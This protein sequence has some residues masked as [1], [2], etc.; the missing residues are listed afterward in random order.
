MRFFSLP[1]FAALALALT[2]S[3]DAVAYDIKERCDH[4]WE[5][6]GGEI[7]EDLANRRHR[8][9]LRCGHI[10]QVQLDAHRV[11]AGDEMF[12]SF[13][14]GS[15][16]SYAPFDENAPCGAPGSWKLLTLC[17]YGCFGADERI[18]FGEEWLTIPEALAQGIEWVS[19]LSKKSS[20]FKPVVKTDTNILTYTGGYEKHDLITFHLSSGMRLSVTK[21][22]PMVA[23]TGEI[24]RADR[25]QLG[26]RLLTVSGPAL[27]SA[28]QRAQ[29]AEK[30][31][32][33]SP[34][35]EGALDNVLIAEGFITGS[36]RFQN[37]WADHA[38]RT[39]IKD[40]LSEG[41]LSSFL[42]EPEVEEKT[43][44]ARL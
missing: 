22:H 35:S 15:K 37:E 13:S 10:S 38:S 20:V 7:Y 3:S 29:T 12:I 33:I 18:L 4:E 28:I 21:N 36:L 1:V 27:I 40:T 26:D 39:L 8:W 30:V 11:L 32:N 42:P 17:P 43:F 23:D 16:G 2:S 6:A 34:V 5:H 14:N 44:P 19:S 24:V 25:V 41:V 9:A 31:W